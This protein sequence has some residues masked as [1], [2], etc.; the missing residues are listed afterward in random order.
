MAYSIAKIIS[1]VLLNTRPA[2]PYFGNAGGAYTA[3]GAMP[4]AGAYG[5]MATGT[6]IGVIR[7]TDSNYK[8]VI[9]GFTAELFITDPFTTA[10]FVS[11]AAYK[12]TNFTSAYSGGI[13]A[14]AYFGT[15]QDS[16]MPALTG[17]TVRVAN[18]GSTGLTT[19]T[20]TR[21]NYIFITD[22]VWSG[23]TAGAKSSALVN[24][25]EED[26][27]PQI[28]H[29]NE[30]IEFVTNGEITDVSGKFGTVVTLLCTKEPE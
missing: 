6:T 21:S 28:L 13:D 11:I 7:W 4:I 9:R 23:T 22:P 27:A 20:R 29:A 26:G 2:R 16:A 24:L 8:L 12:L 10:Q 5:G 15:P 19:G 25:R 30:G 17:A 3:I 1:D 18:A 14:T